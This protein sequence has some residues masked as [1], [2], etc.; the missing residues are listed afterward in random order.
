[1]LEEA[2]AGNLANQPAVWAAGRVA[3]HVSLVW[4]VPRAVCLLVV[5]G[6]RPVVL[7]LRHKVM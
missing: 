4:V 5:K 1:L 6:P 2:G 3:P 7:L